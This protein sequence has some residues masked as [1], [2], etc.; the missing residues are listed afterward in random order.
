MINYLRLLVRTLWSAFTLFLSWFIGVMFIY[1]IDCN[2]WYII[3]A[4]LYC[5]AYMYIAK[6]DIKKTTK[7]RLPKFMNRTI[8]IIFAVLELVLCCV[9]GYFTFLKDNPSNN[10]KD[11]S[12]AV[13]FN[14]M[15]GD[16][17]KSFY[18]ALPVPL[19]EELATATAISSLM[20][21]IEN[22]D[23]DDVKHYATVE[24]S[25]LAD[26]I[27]K[28]ERQMN[29]YKILCIALWIVAG[30]LHTVDTI[31]MRRTN[32]VSD[33]TTNIVRKLL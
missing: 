13:V 28:L 3:V 29:N 7:T 18:R 25:T 32:V 6:S 16:V 14:Q 17:G 20:Y 30:F 4:L 24:L 9:A 2:A 33:I 10:I 15:P 12:C 1:L 22:T 26:N 5:I 27:T 8:F 23:S 11:A 21:T 31:Y 19:H